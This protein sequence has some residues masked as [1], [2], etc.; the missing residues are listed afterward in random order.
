MTSIDSVTAKTDESVTIARD[1]LKDK[2][3]D[4]RKAVEN[5]R[6]ITQT[7]RDKTLVQVGEAITKAD[8]AINNLRQSTQTIQ[9]MIEGQRPVLERALANAQLTTDQL[10]LAAIEIRRSPWRLLYKPTD[11]ELET[12]NLYDAARSFALAAGALDSAAQS[13]QA[14]TAKAPGDR[15]SIEQMLDHLEKLFSRYE[16]AETAFWEALKDRTPQQ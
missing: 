14:V 7:A 3:P 10:K 4:V 1:L 13:L 15:E 8:E 9:T 12:D 16:Q 6:D 5:V 11:D 2:S